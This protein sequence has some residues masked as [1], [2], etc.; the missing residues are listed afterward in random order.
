MEGHIL[1]WANYV[2]GWQKRYFVLKNEEITY[3]ESLEHYQ[4]S[5]EDFKGSISISRNASNIQVT[6]LFITIKCI[7]SKEI[8]YLQFLCEEDKSGW[9]IK[10]GTSRACQ[11]VQINF[12]EKALSENEI[13]RKNSLKFNLTDPSQDTDT[14]DEENYHSAPETHD[15]HKELIVDEINSIQGKLNEY[16]SMLDRSSLYLEEVT[17]LSENIHLGKNT[18]TIS[19]QTQKNISS[20]RP[21][22]TGRSL[23][24]VDVRKTEFS[25][26]KYVSILF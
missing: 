19:T 7:N 8:L 3:Y 12:P 2:Y 9:L 5:A 13:S 18:K 10:I 21:N 1:K 6:G 25:G 22:S 14:L 23:I 4:N 20:S 26:R 15:H 24:H 16:I 11:S 17:E